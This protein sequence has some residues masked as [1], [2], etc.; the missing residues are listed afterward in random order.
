MFLVF[1]NNSLAKL[2]KLENFKKIKKN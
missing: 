1:Q 2:T